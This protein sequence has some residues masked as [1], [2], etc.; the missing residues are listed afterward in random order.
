[1]SCNIIDDLRHQYEL[2]LDEIYD[3]QGEIDEPVDECRQQK[4]TRPT[5]NSNLVLMTLQERE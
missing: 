1:M 4:H 5:L 3:L 2:A